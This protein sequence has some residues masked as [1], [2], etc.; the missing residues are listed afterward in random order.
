M[1]IMVGYDSDADKQRW[2]AQLEAAQDELADAIEK[3]NSLGY[4]IQRLQEDI[5]HLA[6]L[7]GVEVPDPIE[8]LGLTDAIRYVLGT[9]AGLNGFPM[10]PVEIRD[11]L[12]ERGYDIG[13]Y[14]NVMASIHTILRRLQ[15][16]NEIK[17]FDSS[18]GRVVWTGRLVPAPP[19]PGDFKPRYG[20]PDPLNQRGKK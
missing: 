17:L 15:K 11:K 5:V 18:S 4:R 3:Q 14:K 10:T 7:C 16:K 6:A 20:Y 1:I 9:F 2:Q 13:G 8:N 12:S 19:P